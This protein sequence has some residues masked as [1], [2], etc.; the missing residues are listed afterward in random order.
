MNKVFNL[1]KNI[2]FTFYK[3]IIYDIIKEK[4]VLI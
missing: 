3:S 4:G 1:T 2:I